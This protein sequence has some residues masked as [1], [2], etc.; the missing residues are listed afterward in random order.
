MG[1][2]AVAAA[3]L[4]SAPE[5]WPRTALTTHSSTRASCQAPATGTQG[6][7]EAHLSLNGLSWNALHDAGV[8]ESFQS[9]PGK[10]KY[11]VFLAGKT[12]HS[13]WALD[14]GDTLTKTFRDE[15]LV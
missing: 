9:K 11:I 5:R 8:V 2:R 1:R 3:R 4:E 12:R 13:S 6:L 7:W 10:M 14:F 15:N